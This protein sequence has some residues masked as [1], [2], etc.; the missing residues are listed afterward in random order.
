MD[1]Q[2]KGF[3]SLEELLEAMLIMDDENKNV[4]EKSDILNK[5]SYSLRDWAEYGQG[6]IKAKSGVGEVVFLTAVVQATMSLVA[7]LES[8]DDMDGML[9]G[10]KLVVDLHRN[11][12]AIP[13]LMTAFTAGI[14]FAVDNELR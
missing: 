13:A 4:Q 2:K 12:L 14:G 6:I 5:M 1:E 10:M 7:A 9:E 11:K 8:T 3:V